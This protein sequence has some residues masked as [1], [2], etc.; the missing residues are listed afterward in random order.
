MG[1]ASLTKVKMNPPQGNL[2]LISHAGSL[3]WD[4]SAG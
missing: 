1:P 3:L 2:A 4:H